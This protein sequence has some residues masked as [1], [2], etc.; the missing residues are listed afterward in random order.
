MRIDETKKIYLKDGLARIRVG[1][2]Y[3]QGTSWRM[4]SPGYA[5][6]NATS[7]IL[8]GEQKQG[9]GLANYLIDRS[10]SLGLTKELVNQSGG[11]GLAKEFFDRSGSLSIGIF[12]PQQLE[13]SAG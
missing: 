8:F 11:L 10:G 6:E 12:Q 1:V 13:N 4:L 7:G 3:L 2:C 5:L 9:L